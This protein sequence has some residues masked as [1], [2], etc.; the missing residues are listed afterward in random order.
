MPYNETVE[1]PP[2]LQ[3]HENP[4]QWNQGVTDPNMLNSD[5]F[6][7]LNVRTKAPH[8]HLPKGYAFHGQ[9]SEVALSDSLYYKYNFKLTSY[10]H[11]INLKKFFYFIHC[12]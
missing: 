8:A 5:F 1:K 3:I 11:K 7:S 12:H 4:N 2:F 6:D 9:L 10:K